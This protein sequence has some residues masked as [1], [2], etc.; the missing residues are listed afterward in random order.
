MKWFIIGILILFIIITSL[1]IWFINNQSMIEGYTNG[2]NY[3]QS[4]DKD[5]NNPNSCY[6]ISYN[7]GSGNK[8]TG[9]AHIYGKYYI[10]YDG[11]LKEVPDKNLYVPAD[12]KIGYGPIGVNGVTIC[13]SDDPSYN[14][15]KVCKIVNYYDK[16]NKPVTNQRLKLSD[17]VY[18]DVSGFVQQVPYG[19]IAN[20]E[21]NGY[22]ANTDAEIYSSTSDPS[23]NVQSKPQSGTAYNTDNLDITY[24]ADPT[25]QTNKDDSTA[26]PGKM[27]STDACGNL[28]AIP[29]ADVSNTTLYYSPGSYRFGPSNYV[30]NYEESVYL[31]K[32]TNKST[33]TPI[34]NAPYQKAGFC[35]ETKSFPHKK[36]DKCNKLNA[37]TCA[38]TE[39]CVLLGG[40][41]CVAGDETGPK[42][43][44]NYS[45][46]TIVNRDYYY[47]KGKCY[48]NCQNNF[49]I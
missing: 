46:F 39:C 42:I 5:Y 26:G 28:V 4:K 18:L 37:E 12:N 11:Y 16:N 2:F 3:C 40:K 30:P 41:K 13:E 43:R 24:H 48:G 29:Y 6:D 27:W 36:E 23:W 10:S 22:I 44:A 8:I 9:K 20:K 21:R 31:S 32:L 47:Y 1:G 33:T 45:D 19:Y 38:S 15:Q 14:D 34:V 49:L 7:D 35:E 25:K 17:R